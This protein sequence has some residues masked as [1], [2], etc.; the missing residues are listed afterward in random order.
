M[1]R[2]ILGQRDETPSPELLMAIERGQLAGL[3]WFRESLGKTVEEAAIRIARLRGAWPDGIA[4]LFAADEEGGLIQQLSGL[5]ESSGESWL[6][7]PSARA[8]GREGN[9]NTSFAH[10]REIGRRMRLVGLDVALAP[11]VDLDPGPESG[12]LGTR[13]FGADPDQVTNLALAWLRGLASAGI[14]GCMKHF[15]GHGATSLD[16]HTSLPTIAADVDAGPHLEPFQRIARE[17]NRADGTEPSV[18]TAHIVMEPAKLPVTLN[19]ASLVRVPSNLG[20]IWTDS[21]EMDALAPFGGVCAR[22]EAAAAAGADLLVVGVDM[23]GGL[24]L[25]RE[26]AAPSTDEIAGWAAWRSPRP[27][28]PGPWPHTDI[29]RTATAGFR[30][31]KDQPMC[32]GEWDWIL[33]NDFGPYGIV[34][35]PGASMEGRRRIG[36]ILRYD[37]DRP[38]QLKQALAD[39]AERPA[40]VGWLHRGP[41]SDE[42]VEVL[43]ASAGRVRA[44]AHLLDAPESPILPDVWT[45]DTCGFGDCEITSLETIWREAPG[46]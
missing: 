42:T 22:G 19:Q 8:L 35:D 25:A 26:L 16:S 38:E 13:C 28:I 27:P 31:M 39:N 1:A 12:V 9:P 14:R 7:L 45:V 20:P 36:R 10:G 3:L 6:R 18:L 29:M 23:E 30:M 37:F 24:E 15:P 46:P 43:S 2:V 4:C 40:L 44:V 41:P 32:D 11:V 34:P 33:P 5:E 17:W 21:L